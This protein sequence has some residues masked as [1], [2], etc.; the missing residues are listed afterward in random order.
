MYTG[1]EV[2]L[3]EKKEKEKIIKD[4][5]KKEE[6]L[7][8]EEKEILILALDN[9]YEICHFKTDN[10]EFIR[11]GNKN[12]LFPNNPIKTKSYLESLDKL[13]EKGFVKHQGGDLY[14]LTVA[15]CKKAEEIKI[16]EG[17]SI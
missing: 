3:K 9:K 13:I 4:L 12:Y 10:S 1:Y 8:D 2:W 11:V 14:E 6:I 17:K 7:S 15:G 16:V 5:S